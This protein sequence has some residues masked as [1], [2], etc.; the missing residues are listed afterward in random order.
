LDKILP[1]DLL[2]GRGENAGVEKLKEL[3][4]GEPA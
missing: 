1:N 3:A 4:K 2:I